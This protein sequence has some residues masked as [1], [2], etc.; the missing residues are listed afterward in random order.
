MARIERRTVFFR[1]RAGGGVVGLGLGTAKPWGTSGGSVLRRSR[2]NLMTAMAT[3]VVSPS[4]G[5]AA[6]WSGSASGSASRRAKLR[7]YTPLLLRKRRI[8]GGSSCAAGWSSGT[9]ASPKPTKGSS[10]AAGASSGTGE[11]TPNHGACERRCR[12]SM[13]LGERRLLPVALRG[14][15]AGGTSLSSGCCKISTE[16]R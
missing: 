14:A 10:C 16:S 5:R 3:V 2:R 9:G 11:L 7:R 15:T 1:G 4:D 13:A 6:T 12:R 8:V